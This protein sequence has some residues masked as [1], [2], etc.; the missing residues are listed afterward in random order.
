MKRNFVISV[1]CS[2]FFLF[3]G[4]LYSKGATRTVDTTSDNGGLTA[5]TAAASDCSLRGAIAASASSGDVIDFDGGVFSTPRTIFPEST[6]LISKSLTITGPGANL[7]TLTGSNIRQL[8]EISGGV[9]NVGISRVT[10]ANGVGDGGAIRNFLGGATVTVTECVITGNRGNFAGGIR[11]VVGTFIIINSTISNNQATMQGGGGILNESTLTVINSTISGNTVAFSTNGTGA[12]IRTNGPTVITNCTITNNTGAGTNNAS[13]VYSST[14]GVT[15][16]NSIIAGNVNN[17]TVADVWGGFISRGNNLIGNTSSST[18]F[19]QP[20]DLTGTAASPRNPGLAPLGNYG[21]VMQTHA[22]LSNS[23]A[24][25]AGNNCVT[26]LSC[27]QNNPP[28]AIA[29]DQRGAPRKIGAAVDMGAFEQNVTIDQGTLPNGSTTQFYNQTLTATR[30]N[31]FVESSFNS[32]APFTFE[33]IPIAGQGL[34]PG[35]SLASNGQVS[36]QPTTP[37]VY[38][39]TVKATD[40]DGSSGV[41]QYIVQIG[42][43]TAAI[44]SV[45]GRVL[46]PDGSGLVNARVVLTDS[47]GNSFTTITS[48]FGY[49]RFETVEVGQDYILSVSSK[50]YGF[51]P[52]FITVTGEMTDLILLA[53]P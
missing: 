48:S 32:F 3:G 25:N 40:A 5:C 51:A 6:F 28:S 17:S 47:Q 38:T 21:G 53:Q 52:Q 13:G 23:I 26:D 10:I 27:S 15:V 16:R 29:T 9:I 37:G 19:F 42:S 43:T 2:V 7:L 22:L 14:G 44:A 34:P 20:T 39:F 24:I 36:G 30:Q 46:T 8:F 41:K 18:G 35:L 11:N 12:G 50:R 49:Y 31:S 33:L 1:L 4:A 45:S